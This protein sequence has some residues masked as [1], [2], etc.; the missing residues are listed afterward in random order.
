MMK[1]RSDLTIDIRNVS[2]EYRR[3][4]LNAKTFQHELQSWWAGVRGREDPNRKIGV[5]EGSEYFYALKDINFRARHGEAIGIIG[6]NGAGKSTLLKL[7]SRVTAPTDGQIDI[8]GRVV[9]M[10]E[11]GTG[12]AAELTGRENIYFNAS[13]LGMNRKEVDERIGEIIA[14]SGIEPFIDTPIKRYS[15]GMYMKLGF[16]VAAHVPSDI[17]IID[18]V[19]AV[20]DYEFQNKSIEKMRSAAHQDGRTVLCVSHNM[21]HIRQLCDRCI[22]LDRGRILFDGSPE[23]AVGIYLNQAMREDTALDYT[24]YERPSWLGD[25]RMRA[26]CASFEGNTTGV[27]GSGEEPCVRL[28]FGCQ[29]DVPG[30][31]LRIEIRSVSDDRIGTYVLYDICDGR[32]GEQREIV[33]SYDISDLADGA[34]HVVYCFFQRDEMGGNLNIENVPGMSFTKETMQ[35][36]G[37]V[38]WD[39]KEWGAVSLRGA[40]LLREGPVQ[41]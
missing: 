38:L 29:E 31:C 16:A 5:E 33:F 4:E 36:T 10:L 30:I 40:K 13:I 19:L 12:F 3:G 2:K 37:E 9:S 20:G 22:V 15:S 25:T 17:V 34:Y 7:I 11:V 41:P 1:E 24:G 23:E 6:P 26:V 39:T 32:A 21:H 18:E 14:F 28:R 35:G 27:F 8:W